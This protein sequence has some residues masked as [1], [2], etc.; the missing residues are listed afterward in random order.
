[1]SPSSRSPGLLGL[2][3]IFLLLPGDHFPSSVCVYMA[4]DSY[5]GCGNHNFKFCDF[6]L[7]KTSRNVELMSRFTFNF[8]VVSGGLTACWSK[9]SALVFD[10]IEALVVIW[11]NFATSLW[12][13]SP[14]RS[15]WENVN[16]GPV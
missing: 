3:S 10:S 8:R 2:G 4:C 7:S 6:S 11:T 13:S 1:M 16:G 14:T 9:H 12:S 5:G 15:A